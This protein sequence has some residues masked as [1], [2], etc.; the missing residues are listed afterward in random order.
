L[1]ICSSVNRFHCIVSALF[2]Q[3]NREILFRRDKNYWGEVSPLV[4]RQAV[5]L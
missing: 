5:P 1:T 3:F 4:P 2:K